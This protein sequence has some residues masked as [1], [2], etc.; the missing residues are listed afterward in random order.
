MSAGERKPFSAEE[1]EKIRDALSAPGDTL[2]CPACGGTLSLGPPATG[3]S[4]TAYWEVHCERCG[5]G[6]ILQDLI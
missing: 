1:A 3:E 5:R 4:S 6:Q 2:I